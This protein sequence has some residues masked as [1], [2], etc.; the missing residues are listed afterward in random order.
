MSLLF[1]GELVT[2]DGG[3]LEISLDCT[4]LEKGLNKEKYHWKREKERQGG[5]PAVRPNKVLQCNILLW[6]EKKGKNNI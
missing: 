3:L 1:Y 2:M 4:A 5:S 6:G